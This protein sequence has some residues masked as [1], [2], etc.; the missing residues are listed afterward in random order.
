MFLLSQK[1]K[2]TKNYFVISKNCPDYSKIKKH[3]NI[4]TK[5]SLKY[6]FLVYCCANFISTEAPSHLNVLRSNNK[7]FRLATYMKNFIFLQHGVTYMKCHGKNSPFVKGREA[8]PNYIVVGSAKEQEVVCDM[9]QIS[10]NR[11]LKVGLPIF[12]KIKNNHINESSDDIVTVMLTWKPYEEHLYDFEKSDYYKNILEVINLLE[13]YVSKEQILI[14]PHPKIKDLLMSTNLKNQVWGNQISEV[15][16]KSKLLITDYSSVA[17]NSFYQGGAVIFYQPDLELY[18][19]ENGPLIPFD[20]EYIGERVFTLS[21]LKKI[22]SKTIQKKKIN[23]C[24]LRNEEFEKKY[25]EINEFNDGKNIERLYK[26]LIIKNI[27]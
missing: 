2:K 8:E 14:V 15:L 26:E 5:Y 17:Y 4:I 25:K 13:K 7:R 20:N 23:L 9:L 1:S 22:F 24:Q 12:D 21:E 19:K 10:E 16:N 3:K 27:I 6:Y 11:I 18:E